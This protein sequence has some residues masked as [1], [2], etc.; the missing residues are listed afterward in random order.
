MAVCYLPQIIGIHHDLVHFDLLINVF[1]HIL[2]ID[3]L[4]FPTDIITVKINIQIVHRFYIWKW[5][6]YKKI[7]HVK[8]MLWQYQM[9]VT[10]QLCPINNRM[11]QNIFSD[12]K[13]PC[14]FPA[15][16][17]S[18]RKNIMVTGRRLVLCPFFFIYKITDHHIQHTSCRTK[19]MQCIQNLAI[20]CFIYPVIAVYNL[21]IQSGSMIQSCIQ[22]GT[23]AAVL[24]MN[25][26]NNGWVFFRIC[27][28]NRT[29][30][31]GRTIV[32]D[33]NFHIFS[34]DQQRIYTSAHIIL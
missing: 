4:I 12:F 26:T 34:T 10:Q 32:Y 33:N 21:K 1:D 9:T 23:M 19:I 25:G 13:I 27:I 6:I 15:E 31:I 5:H 2:F 24:L 11:H 20:T 17:L 22:S 3:G 7:V 18:L 28:C 16:Q 8:G 29:C 14:L 30:I